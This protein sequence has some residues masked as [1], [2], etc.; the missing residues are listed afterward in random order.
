MY[1]LFTGRLWQHT[2][3][4][5]EGG[6]AGRIHHLSMSVCPPWLMEAAVTQQRS[7]LSLDGFCQ[8]VSTDLQDVS[9]HPDQRRGSKNAIHK[10]DFPLYSTPTHLNLTCDITLRHRGHDNRSEFRDNS[11]IIKPHFDRKQ[12]SLGCSSP[13]VTSGCAAYDVI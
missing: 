1:K 10:R 9:H 2:V 7:H 11:K 12:L 3:K 8:N 4:L 6:R 13:S 5:W